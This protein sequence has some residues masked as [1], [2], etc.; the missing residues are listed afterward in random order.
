M[1]TLQDTLRLKVVIAVQCTA[2]LRS[3][4]P[5]FVAQVA[6]NLGRPDDLAAVRHEI[7]AGRHRPILEAIASECVALQ[8]KTL[9]DSQRAY[10]ELVETVATSTTAIAAMALRLRSRS[11]GR[12]CSHRRRSAASSSS[13]SSASSDDGGAGG[14]GD[15]DPPSR[16]FLPAVSP[17]QLGHSLRRPRGPACVRLRVLNGGAR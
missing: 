13:S 3:M 17:R 4:R 11:V 12:T 14:D 15:S 10:P 2:L 8:D 5:W 7:L 1:A 16:S 6:E 9:H